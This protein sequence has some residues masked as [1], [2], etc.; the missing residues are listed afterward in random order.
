MRALVTGAGG[1]A[2]R[3]LVDALREAGWRVLTSARRGPADLPGD[4]LKIPLRGVSADVVFHLAGFSS[5]SASVEHSVEAY[6]GNAATTARVV[7]ETRAGRFVLASSCQVYGSRPDRSTEE[8]PVAPGTPYAASKLCAEALAFASGKDVVVLRPYNHTGPGQSDDFVCPRIARQI[9]RAESGRGPRMVQVSALSPRRDFFDVRDMVEAYRLAALNAKRGE[10]YNV[11]TGDPVSI[12]E[13][14]K[15]LLAE[16]RV[17]LKVRARRGTADVLS[18]DSVKFRGATGWTPRIPL[19][20][21][22]RDLLDHERA[23]ARTAD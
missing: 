6:A 14:L 11:A 10:I 16:A 7:R 17:P 13:V 18:G 20:K 21:T 23:R 3:R 19:E 15:L 5:P 22:L 4:L 8:T 2:G 1:F 9:A 12:G